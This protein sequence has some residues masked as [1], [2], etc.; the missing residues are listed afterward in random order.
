MAQSE[1]LQLEETA[2]RVSGFAR[3]GKDLDFSR[4]DSLYDQFYGDPEVSPNPCLSP[5][6][7]APFYGLRLDPGDFG[8]CGGLMIDTQARVLDE[9]ENPIPGLYATGNCTA[10]LL[11]TYPGPGA[12]LGPAMTFGYIAGK[13]LVEGSPKDGAEHSGDSH[14]A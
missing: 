13:S 4:G 11:T 1:Y 3:T 12:T 10:G 6:E 14:P 2:K 5:I 7:K 8:T 9:D